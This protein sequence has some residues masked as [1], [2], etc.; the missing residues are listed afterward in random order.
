MKSTEWKTVPIKEVYEELYDGPHATPK[1]SDAG[2]VFLG[3]KNVT[4][5]GRLDLS[6]IRHI[7]EEDFPKWTRRVEPRPGDLVFT[8][9]A[10]LNRYAVIPEGF[11]GCL[12]RRM[13]LIR[14]DTGKLDVRFLLYYFFTS[15]WR[16]VIANKMM[17][18]ATVDRIPLITF[19]D[20]PV[21]VPPLPVQ[22][23]IAGI[24]SAYDELMEN[25]QRRIR[26]LEAMARALYR[27]WFVHFRFPGHE[28]LP[29]VASPLGDIPKGWEATTLGAHLAALESGKRPKGGIRAETDGVPSI[30]AENINGIGR[31]DF[32]GEKLVPREFFEKMRKGVVR[33]RDV[34]IYKDG[35]YIGKSSFFRDGFPHSEC[36]VNEHVFLLRGDGVCLMQNFLYIWL[37]EPDNVQTIRSK[38]ANAA[39]PGINQQTIGGLKLILPDEKAAAHFDRLV[40]PVLADIINLAKRIQTLRRTRDLLLPRLLSGEVNLVG[41]G[42]A[43]DISDGLKP[44]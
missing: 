20:F 36:C 5:D 32:A 29:R 43:Q 33:D 39:Q 27:E 22:Q 11:R 9:E 2:P 18:G 4:D 26:I 23:R 24:L 7:A 31:H 42:A 15:E 16:A 17:S 40:E 28:K 12:G 6:D 44:A 35:A 30:G 25:S 14:P 10:T 37:Q 19:P 13:A 21:R 8:Y 41:T 38:N 1:P 3:I 34:A